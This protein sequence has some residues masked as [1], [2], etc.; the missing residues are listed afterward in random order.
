MT[1]E[2]EQEK[3][4]P[5]LKNFNGPL[6]GVKHVLKKGLTLALK[7]LLIGGAVAAA[8]GF[9]MGGA[10]TFAIPV[11]GPML[12][13]FLAKFGLDAAVKTGLVATWAVTGAAIGGAFGASSAL[14]DAGD[15]VDEKREQVVLREEAKKARD[16]RAA[17]IG[18]QVELRQHAQPA[19]N[20]GELAIHSGLGP[21]NPLQRGGDGPAVS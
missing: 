2:N 4:N 1:D 3:E 6:E 14:L 17:F 16:A 11:I 19:V 18:K 10:S 7:G 15:V 5:A 12:S 20:Q 8:Y 13:P 9:L 21:R